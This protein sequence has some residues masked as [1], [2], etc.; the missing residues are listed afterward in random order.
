VS[1]QRIRGGVR[2]QVEGQGAGGAGSRGS[3][4]GS[5]V[6]FHHAGSH[7]PWRQRKKDYGDVDAERYVD[8]SRS[9]GVQFHRVLK[10]TGSLVIDIGGAWI[11]GQPTRSL[12]H[13]ELLIRSDTAAKADR[14]RISR[15]EALQRV[16]NPLAELEYGSIEVKVEAGVPIWVLKYVRERVG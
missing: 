16:E 9:F 12:Y 3:R 6:P 8:R 2:D 14:I 5:I 10:P 4:G 11:P 1:G 13:Y 15:A 7:L